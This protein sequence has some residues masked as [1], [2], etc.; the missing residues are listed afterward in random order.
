[1]RVFFEA[2]RVPILCNI[3]CPTR[4]AALAVP[5]GPV[6]LGLCGACG[7][8]Y[9]V[10][11][12]ERLMHYDAAYENSLQYSPRFQQY[13]NDLAR[14]LI[15][16]HQLRGKDVIELG[17]GQGDF[18]SLLCTLGPN[19]GLGFDPSFDPRKADTALPAGVKILS[20]Y[21]SEAHVA[22]PVDRLCARHVLEHIPE[23]LA[24]LRSIRRTLGERL[25]TLVFFEVPNALYTLERLG[26]WDIIYEHCSYFTSHSLRRLFQRAGFRPVR[27]AEVFD[28]QFITI[29]A[30]PALAGAT[31]G[32]ESGRDPHAEELA[33]LFE[34][35][36]RAKT[37]RWRERLDRVRREGQRAVVWGVGSKGVTFLNVMS[38]GHE[39]VPYCVDLNPRKHGQFV[40]GTGQ[41]IVP[42]AFLRE[43]R[44]DLVIVMNGIY[45]SEIR[46]AC[47]E[48][49]VDCELAVAA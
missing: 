7:M 23:P 30:N 27:S 42:P 43:Y 19:R 44:P 18:L 17:C 40:V 29:E 38:A 45:E 28:G 35:E 16:R 4:E 5:K 39:T 10:A 21:Y 32:D 31:Q 48:F 15:D 37:A 13:I 26:I 25:N 22:R 47:S 3:L 46:Q 9:N 11:F 6:R 14:G 34:Q 36:Y 49:G 1:M 20:E 41:R 33:T 2:A 24:L 8:V 12:D